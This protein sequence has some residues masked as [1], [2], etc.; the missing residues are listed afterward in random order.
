MA[1]GDCTVATAPDIAG[2][3]ENPWID[4][5]AS[6][7]PVS[8]LARVQVWLCTDLCRCRPEADNSPDGT[9]A[10]L[11]GAAWENGVIKKYRVVA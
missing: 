3:Q 2:E 9:P 8:D 6:G 7:C 1:D 10:H 4:H 11:F 5:D